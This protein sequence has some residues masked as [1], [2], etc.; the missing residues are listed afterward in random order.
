MLKICF[1]YATFETFTN[2][3]Y[4]GVVN[5]CLDLISQ[6]A[7]FFLTLLDKCSSRGQVFT[8]KLSRVL[9]HVF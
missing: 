5:V 6:K 4:H 8:M 2:F 7:K 9:K 3:H 1:S